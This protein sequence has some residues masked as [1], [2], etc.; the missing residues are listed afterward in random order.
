LGIENSDPNSLAERL[1][2]METADGPTSQQPC[3]S[4]NSTSCSSN[5]PSI[6][7]QQKSTSE[8]TT[9]MTGQSQK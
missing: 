2:E 4:G 7:Q 5:N 8:A 9:K 3:C 6:N 1:S